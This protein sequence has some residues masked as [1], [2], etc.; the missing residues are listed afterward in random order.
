VERHVTL[1][2]SGFSLSQRVH[3]VTALKTVTWPESG[4]RA[5]PDLELGAHVAQMRTVGQT[6]HGSPD[7]RPWVPLS[8]P[9][10]LPAAWATA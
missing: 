9:K 7:V 5:C 1:D 6:A 10:A 4:A 8:T 3:E 2:E